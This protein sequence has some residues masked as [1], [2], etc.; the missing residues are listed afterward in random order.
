MEI[1]VVRA[2]LFGADRWTDMM[3]LI[4]RVVGAELFGAD[5]WTDGQ[6]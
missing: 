2:E 4:I 1:R 6:T 3:K 5:R